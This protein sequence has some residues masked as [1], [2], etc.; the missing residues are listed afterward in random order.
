MDL[1]ELARERY[2]VRKYDPRPVEGEKL[3]RILEAGAL[4]PSAKNQQPQHV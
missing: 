4:A 3:D 1:M 2:S